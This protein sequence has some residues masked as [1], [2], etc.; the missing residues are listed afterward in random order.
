M[1]VARWAQAVWNVDRWGS[2]DPADMI[3]QPP[4]NSGLPTGQADWRLVVEILLPTPTAGI[5]GLATWGTAT[6]AETSWVDVTDKVRG[7]EWTRG[8]DEVFGRPRVGRIALT[9]TDQ[10][11]F[12]PWTAPVAQYLAPGTLMRAG[13]VSA[14]GVGHHGYGL[15]SWIPQWTG[16]V[17]EWAPVLVESN[18]ADRFIEVTL[19]ETV[20]DL[21]QV[22]NIA[23]S[24]PVGS[25][26]GA[27]PRTQRLLDAA[28][29]RYGY[30]Q[31]AQNLGVSNY[32]L[33]STI[34]A[35]NRLAELYL[36][37]DSSD[38]QFRS[39]RDGRAASTATEYIGTTGTADARVWPLVLVS[40]YRDTAQDKSTP[41]FVLDST[42]T[43]TQAPTTGF[44]NNWVHVAYRPQTFRSKNQDVEISNAVA[45]ARVG[46]SL[47]EYRQQASIQRYG[48]RSYI[49]TDFLNVTDP[50]VAL[51]AQYVSIRRA[52]ATLRVE[53]VTIDT[54]ARPLAQW[55][56]MVTVEPTDRAR[57]YSPLGGSPRP[58]IGGLV[59]SIT[60]RVSPRVPGSSML[61][62]T[63]VRID[64]RT[65]VNVPGAQLPST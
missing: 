62:E 21:A 53:A 11:E 1:P 43:L 57:I 12:S 45:F 6:W 17:E 24:A 38:T 54:W 4:T 58:Y 44:E 22:D 10:G 3:L 9:L 51:F 19:N 61:W 18:I 64:T 29:F 59:A 25:G 55:Q 56:A 35:Q 46:G 30:L 37:A 5:W 28:A 15:V 7:M 13:L 26:E 16:I 40:W 65:V 27:G 20:R 39:I 34:M 8:S 47:Q 33:Q 60:H 2:L 50:P 41:F 63:D 48:Q 31:E 42:D 32:P 52:L 23:L 49:R 14:A 36:T